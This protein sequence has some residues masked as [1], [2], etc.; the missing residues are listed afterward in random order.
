[1]GYKETDNLLQWTGAV[2][3]ICGH[4]L[5][6]LGSAYHQDLWN[7]IAFA[8]GTV[9]FLIWSVRVSNKPQMMVNVV[10]MTTCV[11]GLLRAVI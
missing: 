9:A 2:A 1:M 4:V 3:I 5:N 10:A 11:V 7:I 8:M 6:T